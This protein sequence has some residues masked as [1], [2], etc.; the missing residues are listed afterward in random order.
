[1]VK[2][3]RVRF[4]LL[5][6]LL[7][8]MPSLSSADISITI[9]PP[10]LPV[11]DQPECPGDGYLWTPG[12]WAYGDDDYYW[13]PGAWILAP[14]PGFLWTPGYW[15][16]EGGNY[17]WHAGYWGQHVGFYGGVNYGFGYSGSGFGGGRWEGNRFL[18]NTAVWRVNNTVVHNTYIDRTVIRNVTVNR[19]SFNGQGGIDARATAEEEA[20]GREQHLEATQEQRTHEQTFI[21]DNNQRFSVNKGNPT[22]T[23]VTKVAAREEVNRPAETPGERKETNREQAVKERSP[24]EGEQVTKGEHENK[25]KEPGAKEEARTKEPANR[26]KPEE[27]AKTEPQ[28]KEHREANTKPAEEKPKP[29]N[30]GENK[31]ENRGENKG[32]KGKPEKEK[33][34]GQ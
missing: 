10:A 17:G 9:A 4:I 30:K 33:D 34:K 29:E 3:I 8:M 11:Y 5:A 21:R 23:T 18:C 24:K 32:E 6:G 15:G 25:G 22:R 19:V 27:K 7:G 12:Y 26:E 1:M 13:V 2:F 20:A 31:G 16:F 14:R 28:N